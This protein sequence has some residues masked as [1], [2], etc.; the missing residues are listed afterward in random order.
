MKRGWK[1]VYTHV[2]TYVG[3]EGGQRVSVQVIDPSLTWQFECN[4]LSQLSVS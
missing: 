1:R 4:I 2:Y 3:D